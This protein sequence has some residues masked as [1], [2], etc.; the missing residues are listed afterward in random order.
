MGCT[1][2]GGP[3]EGL[4]LARLHVARFRATST[5]RDTL[6]FMAMDLNWTV[7]FMLRLTAVVL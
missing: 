7:A 5:Y 4:E 2:Q 6:V 3:D 1:G